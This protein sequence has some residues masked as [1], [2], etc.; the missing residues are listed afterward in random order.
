MAHVPAD[1][2]LGLEG[3]WQFKGGDQMPS[4]ANNEFSVYLYGKHRPDLGD[5]WIK[6]DRITGM[7][8]LG[9]GD[10]F[11]EPAEGRVGEVVYPSGQRGKSYVCEGRVVGLSLPEMRQMAADLRRAA[12][13][14]RER[15]TGSI[16]SVDPAATS[17]GYATGVRCI[18][19][20]IDDEQAFG[21][22]HLPSAW[23]R[24]FSLGLRA[25]DPRWIW[26]PQQ[27][28]LD[29]SSGETVV[30]E[31]EG[32]APAS[33][34]FDIRSEF[35]VMN[36]TLEN[37]SLGTQLVFENLPMP[38]EAYTRRLWINWEQRAAVRPEAAAPAYTP[39]TD[40]MPYMDSS[41]STWWNA[42][43]WGL[44]PG[45]NGIKVSGVG[46]ESWDVLWHHTS[47]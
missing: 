21:P 26:Y 30:I 10:D 1:G 19:C 9:D 43:E 33:L 39:N 14:S 41:E 20:D 5:A 35:T 2:P 46:V 7:H 23:V 32:N 8:G 24:R 18:A 37:L 6:M 45:E 13:E 11:R 28:S 36:V 47:Y 17:A 22:N 27:S 44:G 16:T 12:A 3:R 40:M 31:N 25:H 29:N 15:R 38:D 42:L 4:G 34:F